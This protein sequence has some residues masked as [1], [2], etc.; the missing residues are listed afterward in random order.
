[1]YF[2]LMI[3]TSSQMSSSSFAPTDTFYWIEIFIYF[4]KCWQVTD[5]KKKIFVEKAINLIWEITDFIM[6]QILHENS[7]LIND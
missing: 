4:G 7:Q 6:F 1:M 3:P 5:D 2:F